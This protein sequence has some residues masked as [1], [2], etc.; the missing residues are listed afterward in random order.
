MVAKTFL[1][2][3]TSQIVASR[4]SPVM[5]MANTMLNMLITAFIYWL[6]V[7]VWSDDA[8]HTLLISIVAELITSC[9]F[10]FVAIVNWLE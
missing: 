5:S 1:L 8:L 10:V 2:S 9:L 3:M 6:H 7:W 4:N